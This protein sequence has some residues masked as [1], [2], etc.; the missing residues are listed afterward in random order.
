MY[1]TPIHGAVTHTLVQ[2]IRKNITLVPMSIM[3]AYL[4][5]VTFNHFVMSR[6][7]HE[8]E[9]VKES[10]GGG[11]VGGRFGVEKPAARH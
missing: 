7:C 4:L 8:A 9:S 1:C 3:Q 5:T 10:R 6:F 2:C 11:V